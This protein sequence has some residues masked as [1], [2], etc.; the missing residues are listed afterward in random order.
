MGGTVAARNRFKRENYSNGE[1]KRYENSLVKI[2]HKYEI[3]D[4][5]NRCHSENHAE[6]FNFVLGVSATLRNHIGE[7]GEGYSTNYSENG[8]SGKYP[9]AQV[10]NEHTDACNDFKLI[11]S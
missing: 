4:L 9:H 7:D 10:V 8:N 5:E 1:G 11:V 3:N 2:V 6:I